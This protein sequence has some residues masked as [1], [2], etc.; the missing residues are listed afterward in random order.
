MPHRE[1]LPEEEVKVF[2]RDQLAAVLAMAPS[3]IARYSSSWPRP[4]YGSAR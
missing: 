1:Q 4:A 3:A 2:S